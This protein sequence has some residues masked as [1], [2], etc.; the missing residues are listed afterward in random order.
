MRKIIK[1]HV[2]ISDPRDFIEGR[3]TSCFTLWDGPC[4]IEEWVDCGEI[5]FVIDVDV[6]E[7]HARVIKAID[8]QIEATREDFNA[9]MELLEAKRAEFLALT[10]SAEQKDV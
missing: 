9:R 10:Y 4:T 1:Q 5:E 8:H 6:E 7:L 2:V 3:F